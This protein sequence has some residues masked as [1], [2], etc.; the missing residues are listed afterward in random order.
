VGNEIL[1]PT[2]ATWD[3]FHT[4]YDAWV[5]DYMASPASAGQ[6]FSG[7]EILPDGSTVHE[8]YTYEVFTASMATGGTGS[9]PHNVTLHTG[10]RIPRS[11]TDMH[12]LYK[13]NPLTDKRS[14]LKG[15]RV[16]QTEFYKSYIQDIEDAKNR[17]PDDVDLWINNFKKISPQV[18]R[19]KKGGK[20]KR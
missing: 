9:I 7:G 14:D 10:H 12:E 6:F 15:T 4:E 8:D 17:D 20:N 1:T 19:S 5:K 2:W 11:R 3:A 18:E 16:R 13:F